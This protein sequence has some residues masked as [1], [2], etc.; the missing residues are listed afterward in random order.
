MTAKISKE[1]RGLYMS[2][3]WF[4]CA[5]HPLTTSVEGVQ[6]AHSPVGAEVHQTSSNHI[7]AEVARCWGMSS[8]W[9]HCTKPSL[10]TS[11]EEK[12]CVRGAHVPVVEVHR[13]RTLSKLLKPHYCRDSKE[14][15]DLYLSL[16]WFDCTEP[17]LTTSHG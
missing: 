9:F 16:E 6:G 3:E 15:R 2:S 17:S 4:N 14:W 5:E 8:K 10:S 1:W 7:I 11:V 13:H 12:Q